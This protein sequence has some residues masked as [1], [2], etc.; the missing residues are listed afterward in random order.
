LQATLTVLYQE[1]LQT[2]SGL[3][4]AG[5]GMTKTQQVRSFLTLI[6]IGVAWHT[7]VCAQATQAPAASSAANLD[8][9]AIRALLVAQRETTLVSQIVGRVDNIYG[10]LGSSF[11]AGATLI[12][13]DCSEYNAR[14]KMADAEFNA[15]QQSHEGKIRL[16]GL[17]AAGEIEV[18]TAAAQ[19]EK[20]KAQ[21][22]LTKTQI[23]QCKVEA[24]FAGRIVKMNVR[25]HQGVNV[26]QPML[27]IISAGP[28]K[29]KLNAPSKWL[30]WLKPGVIFELQ[31]DETGQ[32]YQA[33]VTS[34]NGKV[35]PVSQSI[36][37]EG[38]V[39]SPNANLL[40]GMSGNARFPTTR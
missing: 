15:A 9:R 10:D 33:S 4:I 24:P 35:D 22:E 7:P 32:Y 16:Q 14:L 19:M 20:A 3:D 13:F 5:D 30:S 8:V 2:S 21:I 26:G 37:I 1:S 17:N 27:E 34:L 25:Q 39:I 36:E 38:R 11:R 29:I 12:Q 40:A 31:V 6:F 28:P 23:R 18:A